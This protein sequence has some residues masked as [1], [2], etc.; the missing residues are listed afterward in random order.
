MKEYFSINGINYLFRDKG[1][2][3]FDAFSNV[4]M[5]YNE[6]II[7]NILKTK[8]KTIILDASVFNGNVGS[9]VFSDID[10]DVF[11]SDVDDVEFI[12]Y[13]CGS[14]AARRNELACA[15]FERNDLTGEV[16]VVQRWL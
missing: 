5:I 16:L 10:D 9:S 4:T 2:I 6:D 15:F 12:A 8:K 7:S 14:E 3:F 1:A 13:C 11:S